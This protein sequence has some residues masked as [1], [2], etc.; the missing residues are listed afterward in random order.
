MR[1]QR[2]QLASEVRLTWQSLD[3]E[4]LVIRYWREPED[5][6]AKAEREVFEGMA[7]ADPHDVGALAR[8]LRQSVTGQGLRA[9]AAAAVHAA[10]AAPERMAVIYDAV[11]AGW[12]GN[13]IH[14]PSAPTLEPLV[15]SSTWWSAFWDIATPV[16]G[17]HRR[18]AQE[19]MVLAGELD[20]HINRRMA[21]AALEFPGVVEA[22]AQGNA[23]PYD[24]EWLSRFPPA[25]LG[26]ALSEELLRAK[27]PLF[28]PYWSS[29]LPYLRHM[30]SPL[31]YINVEVIQSMPLWALVAGYTSRGLDR[32]AY[33]GFLMGQV[34]HH[35]SALASA[36]TLTS[37]AMNPPA[38]VEVLLDC[39][40]KGWA[41]GRATP[42]L[43]RVSWD[44]LWA[45]RVDKV[46]EVLQIQPFESPY[47]KDPRPGWVP[48]VI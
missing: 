48:R 17:A 15:L 5:S 45:V 29:V 36:V 9:L 8:D 7:A 21:A 28:D 37:A 40:L 43:L 10:A 24:V 41:H 46:R 3:C 47:T 35:Y 44:P 19:M 14:P 33:G 4:H 30:P 1:A 39:I 27:S 26:Y 18:F 16:A 13:R 23:K 25:A 34:G 31:N 2:P 22:A 20:P 32:V 11:A 38:N 6:L 42:P 12:L